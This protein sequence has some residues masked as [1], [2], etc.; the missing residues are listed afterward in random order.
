MQIQIRQLL[1]IP[2]ILNI[3][4]SI[5]REI[6]MLKIGTQLKKFQI[7]QLIEGQDQ[8]FQIR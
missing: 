8:C 2:Q 1:T 3:L 7:L 6:Q 5:I 4:Y